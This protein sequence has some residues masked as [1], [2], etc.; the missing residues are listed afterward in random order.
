MAY[1]IQL[2]EPIIWA[3]TINEMFCMD[4]VNI[5]IEYFCIDSYYIN[6]NIKTEPDFIVFVNDKPMRVSESQPLYHSFN[7]R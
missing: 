4:V 6:S 5:C 2:A 7:I 1:T 3:F